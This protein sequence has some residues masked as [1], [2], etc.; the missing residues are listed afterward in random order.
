MSGK[1]NLKLSYYAFAQ[2]IVEY[3]LCD[4][5]FH[6]H[7]AAGAASSSKINIRQQYEN[8]SAVHTG[9]ALTASK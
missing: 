8:A 3:L 9:T 1:L 4:A 7:T 5:Q 6:D 2:A